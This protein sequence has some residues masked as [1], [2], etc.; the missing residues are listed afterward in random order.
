MVVRS[1]ARAIL[2]PLIFYLVLGGASAY[3]VKNASKGQHGA[4]AR[5]SFDKELAAQKAELAARQDERE[6]WRRQ[7][8]SLRNETIDRDLLEQEAHRLL[9]RAGPDE[10]AIFTDPKPR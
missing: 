4:D 8:D 6:R 7:V 1:R 10:V 9:D 5:A 3:L 2:V